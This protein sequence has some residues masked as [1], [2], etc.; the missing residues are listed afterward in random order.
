MAN[1]KLFQS[2]V[3]TEKLSVPA[4]NTVNNAGGKAYKLSSK[5][6][7]AQL[8]CTGCFGSTYYVSAND[9]LKQVKELAR[10]VEPEF[11]VKLAVYSRQHAFMKDM[12]ALMLAMVHAQNRPLF[13]KT[14]SRVVQNG[15]MLKNFCQ[16]VRSG[17]TGRKSFGSCAKRLIQNWIV[18]RTPEQLVDDSI[19]NDPSLAD[20]IK[21]VHP[22]PANKEQEA[23]FNWILGKETKRENLPGVVLALEAFRSGKS[24]AVPNVNFQLLTSKELTNA[25]WK[26][27]AQTAS[28]HTIRMNLNT[29][30]RHGVLE[31]KATV[32]L[33]TNKLNEVPRGVFPYQLMTSFENASDIPVKLSNALQDAVDKAVKNIPAFKGKVVVCVDSSGSMGSPVTGARGTA[34]SKVTCVDVASLVA[35][36]VVNKAD[37]A[38]VVVFDTSAEFV[39]L[40]PR[41]SIMTNKKIINRNGGGTDCSCAMRLLNKSN[42]KADLVLFVSDNE[43]W[44]DR[45]TYRGT[46]LMSEWVQF[47][48]RNPKAKLVCLD[49]TP[50]THT[51]APDGTNRLNV[52]GFSDT[53][54]QVVQAFMESSGSPDFWVKKI[55]ET[56][57][58]D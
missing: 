37:D 31:D 28:W 55:E 39:K 46:G 3:K 34:T 48:A 12:P 23:L 9:Q 56:V 25:Q 6:A 15:K 14:F 11:L 35:A 21:M 58:L 29:F 27:V 47:Q 49:I 41:D 19:G 43:S 53:V 22:R 38:E 16:I 54:F 36:C 20:V 32:D 7:L 45:S 50:N 5:H 26:K 4:V 1:K 51:Q 40:N 57:S 42:T 44:A 18:N 13:E 17:V 24:D 30:K 8:A 10:E 33:L 52:G 2:A